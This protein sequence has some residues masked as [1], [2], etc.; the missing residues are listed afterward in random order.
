VPPEREMAARPGSPEPELAAGGAGAVR[1]WGRRE[2]LCDSIWIRGP[3]KKIEGGSI[4]I[5][6]CSDYL[7]FT[8]YSSKNTIF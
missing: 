5:S 1:F 6:C 7:I 4:V 2:H 8:V 3:G